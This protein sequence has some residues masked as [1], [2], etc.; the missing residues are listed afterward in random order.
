MGRARFSLEAATEFIRTTASS[1][2][3]LSECA[4]AWA[5]YCRARGYGVDLARLA[6]LPFAAEEKSLAR[7]FERLRRAKPPGERHQGFWF[8][9][10]E[11]E[12]GGQ[13]FE[14][15]YWGVVTSAALD[16]DP[17]EWGWGKGAI[18]PKG[19][20]AGSTILKQLWAADGPVPK[21]EARHV[22][23]LGYVALVAAR[24]CLAL[25]RAKRQ[26]RRIVAVGYDEGDLVLLGAL[27][28]TGFTTEAEASPKKAPKPQRTLAPAT[29]FRVERDIHR[30]KGWL[31]DSPTQRSGREVAY[32]FG[33]DARRKKPVPLKMERYLGGREM[34]F[35]FTVLD[36]PVV[37][38]RVAD[39][40]TRHDPKSV[41]LLPVTL[42]GSR[43]RYWVLNVVAK[44]PPS[45]FKAWTKKHRRPVAEASIGR[46][47]IAR[48]GVVHSALV[49]ARPLAEALVEAEVTGISLEPITREDVA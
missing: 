41:Q 13:S 42:Q 23:V 46:R 43:E 29:L 15:F 38:R 4:V 9:V 27:T 5:K 6:R 10:N 40:I 35:S 22:F 17:S 32:G 19:R 47:L 44:V 18:G 24:S 2:G 3:T 30:Q 49:V 14:D 8:G 25:P 20:Y 26:L 37:N 7:W 48:A 11:F 34:D 39:I 31:L 45:H 33:A 12:E 16:V 28:D 21:S 1:E 36:V